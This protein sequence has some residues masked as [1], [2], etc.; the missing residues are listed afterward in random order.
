VFLRAPARVRREDVQLWIDGKRHDVRWAGGYVDAGR[1]DAGQVAAL[2][3]PL[4]LRSERGEVNR[5]VQAVAWKGDTVLEV[6]PPG[7]APVPYQRTHLAQAPLAWQPAP[8][9]PTL[10]A[11][12]SPFA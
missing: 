5:E 1:L 12:L 8:A 11:A 6:W 4:V 9:Y 3:Y 7:S 10:G 2:R